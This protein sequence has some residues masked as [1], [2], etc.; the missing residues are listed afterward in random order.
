MT[1][2]TMTTIFTKVLTTMTR[3]I[4][5][6]TEGAIGIINLGGVGRILGPF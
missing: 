5:I 6:A 4:I 3:A 2:T 1:M